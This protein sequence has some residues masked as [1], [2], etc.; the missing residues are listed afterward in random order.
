MAGF[1]VFIIGRF[2]VITAGRFALQLLS[3][4]VARHRV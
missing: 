4:D 3:Y 2:R 1:Q